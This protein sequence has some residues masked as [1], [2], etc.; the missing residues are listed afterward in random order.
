MAWDS[1]FAYEVPGKL[2]I[3]YR[4]FA[5]KR[6]SEFLTALRDRKLILA[7]KC[8]ACGRVMLPPRSWCDRC[9]KPAPEQ[10]AVGPAGTVTAFTVVRYSG[11]HL[12]LRP[13][14]VLANIL[15]DGADTALTH[16]VGELRPEDA[17][18][19]LRVEAVFAAKRQARIGDIAHFRP[20]SVHLPK[21][22]AEKARAAVKAVEAKGAPVAAA[23]REQGRRAMNKVRAAA[24]SAVERARSEVSAAAKVRGP[25]KAKAKKQTAKARPV[26]AAARPAPARKAASKKAAAKKAPVKV[27]KVVTSK[28]P[29]KSKPALKKAVKTRGRKATK[30]GRKK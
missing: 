20:L 18:I 2:E 13:P 22:V 9:M 16:L 24:K 30:P 12:P 11:A 28:P 8:S 1:R 17:A 29:P 25:A 15:L 4:Y 6:G 19:G 21:P 3:P 23:V 26:K 7:S 27:K 14:Y 10:V 5:G